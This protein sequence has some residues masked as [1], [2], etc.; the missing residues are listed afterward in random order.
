[1]PALLIPL[2]AIL[3]RQLVLRI[4]IATGIAFVTYAGYMVALDKFKDYIVDAVNSMPADI[5]NLLLIGGVGQGMGYL[6]GAFAFRIS[7]TT[8]NKLTFILPK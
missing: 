4:I 5:V 3:L 1:M 7:M 2:L 8:L 6:F